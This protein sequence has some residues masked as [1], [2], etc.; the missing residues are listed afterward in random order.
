[1]HNT[2]KILAI[3][4][5]LAGC[6]GYGDPWPKLNDPLPDP[7][8]R[9][10][11][12]ATADVKITPHTNIESKEMGFSAHRGQSLKIIKDI[13]AAWQVFHQGLE[14][15]AAENDPEDK[16]IAWTGTQLALSRVSAEVNRLRDLSEIPVE[17]DVTGDPDYMDSLKEKITRYDHALRDAKDKVRAQK[18][19]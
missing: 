17:P 13:D 9:K 5:M 3:T 4:L 15:I 1:M 8:E 12:R 18:P 6:S 14:N 2:L 16:R 10:L 11:V 19:Q 7:D